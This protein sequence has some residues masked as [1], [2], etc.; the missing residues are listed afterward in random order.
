LPS[1]VASSRPAG[2]EQVFKT[3]TVDG[4]I[5]RSKR[6]PI[7]TRTRQ[8]DDRRQ[9]I[10]DLLA[11]D[12]SPFTPD[13]EEALRMSRDE[14]SH[15]Y[16]DRFLKPKVAKMQRRTNCA[17]LEIDRATLGTMIANAVSEAIAGFGIGIQINDV[18]PDSRHAVANFFAP[19]E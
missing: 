14:I 17:D 11:S 1:V 19:R 12:D 16:R 3:H 13:D 15:E 7:E 6:D 5:G 2:A 10:A 9:I 8:R 18:K 4:G